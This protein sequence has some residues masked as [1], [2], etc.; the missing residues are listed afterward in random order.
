MTKF[1]EFKVRPIGSVLTEAKAQVQDS[2]QGKT[3]VLRTRW[4]RVNRMLLGG[5]Y[6]GQTYLIAG[7]S[8]HGKSYLVNMLLRDFTNQQING[9]LPFNFKILHFGFEMAA[10]AEVLRRI[11]SMTGLSYTKL[12]SVEDKLS[13]HEYDLV[14]RSL[15]TLKNEEIYFVETPGSRF[16]VY[17]TIKAFKQRFPD[18]E[19]VVSLDHT[20]LVTP[21][22]G[23]DE[24]QLMAEVSKLFIQ[25]R[26]EF[27]TM[28]LLVSQLNDKIEGENRR[29]P[30][31]PSLHYPTKTDLHGSK[32][33][34]QAADCVLVIHRPEL[35]NLEYYGKENFPTR[36]LVALHQIKQRNGVSGFTLMKNNLEKGTFDDW[37]I[38]QVSYSL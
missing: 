28:N 3:K 26:K 20:L 24:I 1:S 32:Q 17:E 10:S 30:A 8:G 11:T 31:K 18:S 16:Q 14:Q 23:E 21:E 35:L 38:P 6:F 7:A 29:D 12:L 5:F 13:D 9:N 22:P 15:V 19:L 27:H 25:I 34:Y 4:Q 33:G 37:E 36:D 2:R